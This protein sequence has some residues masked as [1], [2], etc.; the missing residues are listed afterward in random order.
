MGL[1][2]RQ[3]Q[4][5]WF[6]SEASITSQVMHDFLEGLSLK[7][8]KETVVIL[9]N[10]P[11]HSA[12]IISRQ[13]PTWQKRGLFIVFLPPYSPHLNIAETLWRKVKIEWLIPEDY[14]D[15][16][17]LFYA[18]NRCMANIGKELNIKFKKFTLN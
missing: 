3:N 4:C 1:I 5:H 15:K 2:N 10:A 12:K 14:L 7:I 16:D 11:I 8:S 17:T 18:A 6:S 13:I 9:D